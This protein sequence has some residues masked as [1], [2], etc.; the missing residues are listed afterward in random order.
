[1]L[2]IVFIKYIVDIHG[3]SSLDSMFKVIFHL[4]EIHKSIRNIRLGM[5]IMTLKR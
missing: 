1:M 2:K 3:G 4:R 5:M